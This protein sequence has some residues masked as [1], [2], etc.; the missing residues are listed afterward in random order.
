MSKRHQNRPAAAVAA[1]APRTS[2]VS[3]LVGQLGTISLDSGKF[4][5][6]IHPDNCRGRIEYGVCSAFSNIAHSGLV[7]KRLWGCLRAL[8]IETLGCTQC[9]T[10]RKGRHIPADPGPAAMVV[11]TREAFR[12]GTRPNLRQAGIRRHWR[13]YRCGTSGCPRRRCGGSYST[14]RVPTH[15]PAISRDTPGGCSG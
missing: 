11:T 10:V 7:P 14:V 4:K 3:G 1:G 5:P 15:G 2:Q 8:I 12:T 6:L 9:S 13:Q